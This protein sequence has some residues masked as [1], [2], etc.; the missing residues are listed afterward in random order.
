MNDEVKTA[1]LTSSFIVPT[2]DLLLSSRLDLHD[3][4]DLR[5]YVERADLDGRLY[6]V[7]AHRT[8]SH[9]SLI[10][11]NGARQRTFL[12]F[13]DARDATAERLRDDLRL[14]E[15]VARRVGER[16]VESPVTTTRVVPGSFVCCCATPSPASVAA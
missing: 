5:V 16:T 9:R 12:H 1:C 3:E 11:G 2:S 13:D 10:D 7:R 15:R 8:P 14:R 4:R 6:S